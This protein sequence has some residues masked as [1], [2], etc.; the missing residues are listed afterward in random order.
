VGVFVVRVLGVIV[1]IVDRL[2][3]MFMCLVMCVIVCLFLW[4]NRC[5]KLVGVKVSGSEVGWLKIVV[6]VLIVEMLCRMFGISLMCVNVLCVWCR[7]I[8]VLVVLLV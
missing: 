2:V 5:V 7:L 3:G 1:F 8:L 6:E 4:W